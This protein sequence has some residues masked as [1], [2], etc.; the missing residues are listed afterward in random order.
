MRTTD[1]NHSADSGEIE[2]VASQACTRSGTFALLLAVVLFL[3]STYWIQEKKS[4]AAGQYVMYRQN[5]VLHLTALDEDTF[6]QGYLQSNPE[7][8]SR[9][10]SSLFHVTGTMTIPSK[11]IQSE[12][13]A[14]RAGAAPRPPVTPPPALV[15]KRGAQR[16]EQ[17]P[18]APPTGITATLS[19]S[20]GEIPG[21]AQ[22]REDLEAL[23]DSK[24]LT[25]ARQSSNFFEVSIVRWVSKLSTIIY[26]NAARGVCFAA[27][28]ELPAK[29]KP[30]HYTPQFDKKALTDCLTLKNV[31]DLG[32]FETPTWTN[33]DSMARRA[34][35]DVDVSPGSLP[36]DPYMA[37]ITAQL[38]L[39]LV[40]TY[41]A[42]FVREAASCDTF[43]LRGTLFGAFSKSGWMIVVFLLALWTP[44]AACCAVLVTSAM[45][46]LSIALIPMALVTLFVQ[47]TLEETTF[48][49]S[50]RPLKL[51]TARFK[52]A[53]RYRSEEQ[54]SSVPASDCV[55][56]DG[57]PPT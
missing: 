16:K 42:V 49:G 17:L 38:L 1:P 23:N 26:G 45:A 56:R 29:S 50:I 2:A 25:R 51:L 41:F 46:T 4:L 39:F 33:P 21:I 48:F 57:L 18:P 47:R 6:W 12:K 43:P 34:A 3:L 36:K 8:E 52:F 32:A 11:P 53:R 44:F 7:A 40:L 13:G 54:S 20:N 14:D 15:P 35:Q 24:L 30:A 22:V 19:Y 5:L 31:R 27:V 55:R 28:I 37:T 10:L 9:P